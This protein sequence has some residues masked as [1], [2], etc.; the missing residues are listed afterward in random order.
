MLS[1]MLQ[2]LFLNHQLL[3]SSDTYRYG[4]GVSSIKQVTTWQ[5][6]G[7]NIL[8]SLGQKAEII[9]NR[10]IPGNCPKVLAYC[11]VEGPSLELK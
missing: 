2:K 9:I 3:Y 11:T 6:Y 1:G 4:R 8:C 7:S 10:V 5:K